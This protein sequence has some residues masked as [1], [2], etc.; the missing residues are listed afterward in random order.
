MAETEAQSMEHLEAVRD[1]WAARWEEALAHWSRFT[2]LQ[3]PRWCFTEEEENEEGLT[4]SFAMIRLS[5]HAVV[6]SIRQ[7][8]E[9]KLDAFAVEVMAHEIG[10]HVYCPADL[11]D[12]GRTIARIRAGLPSKEHLAGFISNLYTDLLINDRLQRQGGLNIAGVYKALGKGATDKLWTL[13]MRIYEIL[14]R[15]P[16]KTLAAGELTDEVEFDAQL[17]ARLIR[18]YGREWIDGAGRFAALCLPYLLQ[19][20]GAG[21]RQIMKGWFDTQN[22]GAGG[23]PAGLSEIEDEEQTGA[24]HPVHDPRITGVEEGDGAIT[25]E[26]PGGSGRE[27]GAGGQKKVGRYRGP[28]EYGDILKSLGTTLSPEEVT[29]RYYRERALPHLIPFPTRETTRSTEP[30]PEGLDVWDFGSPLANAD[31]FESV[32]KS[33]YIIPGMTTVQRTYGETAGM[34]PDRE[35]LDL[36]IGIDCS[37]SMPNPRLR[38][39]FPVIAGTIMALSAFRAGARVMAT[40]S[41]E[42]GRTVTTDAFVKEERPV[43]DLL[44][45]YLGTGYAFGIHRLRPVFENRKPEDR[46]VH[47]LIITDQDIFSMLE[48]TKE[49]WEGWEV[50]WQAVEAGRGGGTFVLHMPAHWKDKEVERMQEIGWNVFR[51]YDWEELIAF[52]RE[53]SRKMYVPDTQA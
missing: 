24:L 39:S 44:T 17:G 50:A 49:K 6:I 15:L 53:F 29:I 36:Y 12:H 32:L 11:T 14:W 48:D 23:F 18:V 1:A 33:P 4:G 34:E 13:Y 9:E 21:M 20:E 5:D 16:K 42:P 3:A 27:T 37:G 51:I 22:A 31:W 43:M 47:I 28:K 8:V 38:V 26:G 19:D 52:A 41:G 35:P 46:P 30:L 45:G 40:L 7:I 10:H 2:R 25:S